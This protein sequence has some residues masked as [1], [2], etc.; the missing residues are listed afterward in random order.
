MPVVNISRTIR[1]MEMKFSQND[2]MLNPSICNNSVVI[3]ENP[4]VIIMSS[5][6]KPLIFN[7][8]NKFFF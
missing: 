7:N 2:A 3:A 8:F 4:D 1:Y 6:L 5:A